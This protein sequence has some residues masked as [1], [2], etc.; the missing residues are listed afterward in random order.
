MEMPPTLC[1]PTVSFLFGLTP[2]DLSPGTLCL[3]HLPEG[4][5]A[6]LTRVI[7]LGVSLME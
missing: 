4:L 5:F 2:I 3:W 6:C 7:G 1:F